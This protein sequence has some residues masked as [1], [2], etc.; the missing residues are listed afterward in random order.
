MFNNSTNIN[1]T[2]NHLSRQIT[3]HKKR[4]RYE[5]GNPGPGLRQTW[6][7][8]ESNRLMES[9]SSPLDNWFSNV[10]YVIFSVNVAQYSF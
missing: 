3:E 4:P 2:N 1:K 10:N 8:A 7:Y 9:Q 6:K 5:V